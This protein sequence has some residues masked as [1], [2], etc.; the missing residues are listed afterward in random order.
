MTESGTAYMAYWFLDIDLMYNKN[1][2]P[3]TSGATLINIGLVS[4]SLCVMCRIWL[5]EGCWK[6]ILHRGPKIKL[7]IYRF[8]TLISSKYSKDCTHF[9]KHSLDCWKHFWKTWLGLEYSRIVAFCIMSYCDTFHSNALRLHSNVL[10]HFTLM[11]WY[12]T[13]MLRQFTLMFWYT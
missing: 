7:L 6:G 1:S 9:S 11:L 13:L 8:H 10:I 3:E 4:H 5:F 12:F 2:I